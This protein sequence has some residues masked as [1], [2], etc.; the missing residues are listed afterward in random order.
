MGHRQEHDSYLSLPLKPHDLKREENISLKNANVVHLV[1]INSEHERRIFHLNKK[2][3][4]SL[5]TISF[6]S[7]YWKLRLLFCFWERALSIK[8]WHRRGFNSFS[9]GDMWYRENCWFVRFSGHLE[10]H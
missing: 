6:L 3:K 2:K 4:T 10:T 8:W 9:F 7:E 5:E 1:R